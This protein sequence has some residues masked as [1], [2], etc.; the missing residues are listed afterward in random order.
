[1]TPSPNPRI[2]SHALGAETANAPHVRPWVI[3]RL[4]LGCLQMIGATISFALIVHRGITRLSLAAVIATGILTGTS[5]F[6]FQV[7]KRDKL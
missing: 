5:M 6:L 7:C 4:I 1:M 3:V 2:A